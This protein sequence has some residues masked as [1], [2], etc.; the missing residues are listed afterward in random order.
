MC[1]YMHVCELCCVSVKCELLNKTWA[2]S[3]L[4]MCSGLM[5]SSVANSGFCAPVFQVMI[6]VSHFLLDSS[7]SSVLVPLTMWLGTE[8]LK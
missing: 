3:F 6:S 1:L 4:E 8:G 7:S 5:L 2:K